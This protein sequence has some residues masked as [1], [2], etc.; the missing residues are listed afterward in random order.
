M[1]ELQDI[2]VAHL[3]PYA[4]EAEGEVVEAQGILKGI[5]DIDI[6]NQD[7][8]NFAS[9]IL[10]DIK[11]KKKTL[12]NER[13]K[14]TRPLLD[15]LNVIRGWFKP[16]VEVLA[17]CENKLKAKISGYHREQREKQQAA[18]Q[19]AGDASMQGDVQGAQQA[20]GRAQAAEV[21]KAPGVQMREVIKFEVFDVTQVPREFLMI[22]E[23]AIQQHIMQHG[24]SVEI[25]GV[26]IWRDFSV[27]AKSTQG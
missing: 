25:S 17:Q 20:M 12:E 3:K 10:T 18:L 21:H 27:A 24:A 8:L 4:A 2:Q 6:G 13:G 26:K 9:E 11:G 5:D 22:N 19:A 14:A 1:T 15:A 7:D 16:A 23:R